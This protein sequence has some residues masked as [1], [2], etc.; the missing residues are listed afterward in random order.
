MKVNEYLIPNVGNSDQYLVTNNTCH[1][2]E[3]SDKSVCN[4]TKSSQIAGEISRLV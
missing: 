4:V 1:L 2:G 3:T